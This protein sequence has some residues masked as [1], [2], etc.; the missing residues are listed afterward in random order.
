M[1]SESVRDILEHAREFHRQLGGYYAS[2]RDAS[3]KER[4]RMLLDYMSAHERGLDEALAAYE[5]LAGKAVIGT[6]YKSALDCALL[7]AKKLLPLRHDMSADEVIRCAMD[8][9]HCLLDVYRRLAE[10]AVAEDVKK[11]FEGLVRETEKQDRRLI[12]D[13]LELEDL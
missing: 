7:E 8:V 12:R 13:A 10:S 9:D 2:L 4:V 11:L 6:W 1:G 3:E 5:S